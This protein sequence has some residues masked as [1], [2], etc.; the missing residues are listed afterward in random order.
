MLNI[1]PNRV[2]SEIDKNAYSGLARVERFRSGRTL[3]RILIVLSVA[4]FIFLFIPWTQNIRSKGKVTTMLPQQR[5]QVIQSVIDGRIEN[6]YVREG[7]FVNKG[8]TIVHISEIKDDYFD[9]KLLERTQNQ[10]NA[11][12]GSQVAY[13]QKA[14]ALTNQLNAL[15]YDRDVKLQQAQNKLDQARFKVVT[16]SIDLEAKEINLTIARRQFD[17]QETLYEKGLKSRTEYEKFQLQLQKAI[18]ERT[19]AENDLDV[20]RASVANAVADFS[21]IA[22]KYQNDAAKVASDRFSAITGKYETEATIAKLENQLANYSARQGFYYITA[23]QSGYVTQSI[24]SGIGET[25]K[26]GSPIV[27]IMPED[28][29]LAI[30]MFVQPLDL[31]LLEKGQEIM[32]VFDGWPAIVFSGWPNSSYGTYRGA[33]FAIDRFI[34]DNG[35]YRILVRQIPEDPWPELIRVGGGANG[36]ILLKDVPIWYELWRNLNGFPPD[37]YKDELNVQA[38]TGKRPKLK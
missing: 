38:A 13:E 29:E 37:F 36:L 8:D 25:I 34:S 11:K 12:S 27:S 22:A 28:F 15:T 10:I 21:A 16:D 20:S 2:D 17:R 1:S 6:W 7:D 18:A 35:L 3:I 14:N 24:S 32:I 31:P 33:I 5:P 26:Q 4:L 19:A 9:Q 23:P 30:E